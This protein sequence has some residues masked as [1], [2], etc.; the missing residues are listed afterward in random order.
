VSAAIAVDETIV[1][2]MAHANVPL[3]L[4]APSPT[5]IA[6]TTTRKLAACCCLSALVFTLLACRAWPTRHAFE[7][8]ITTREDCALSIASRFRRSSGTL[9]R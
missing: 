6:A 3:G 1:F 9:L 7:R 2:A 4:A 8:T 5:S